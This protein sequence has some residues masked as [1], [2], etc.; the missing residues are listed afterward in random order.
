MKK[1]MLKK[2]TVGTVALVALV[3]ILLVTGC[4]PQK[5][6]GGGLLQAYSRATGQYK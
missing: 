6:G 3:G 2:F 1:M 5:V 4:D